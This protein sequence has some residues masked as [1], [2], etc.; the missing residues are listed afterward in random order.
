MDRIDFHLAEKSTFNDSKKSTLPNSR[1]IGQVN[2]TRTE[3]YLALAGGAIPFI[4]R[5]QPPGKL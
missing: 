4:R 1:Q 2:P 5:Y 3:H